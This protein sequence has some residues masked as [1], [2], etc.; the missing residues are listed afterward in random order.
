MNR[1]HHYQWQGS[2]RLK[3]SISQ[4]SCSMNLE[5]ALPPG[6]NASLLFR[7]EGADEV[8]NNVT[9]TCLLTEGGLLSL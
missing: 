5:K 1:N 2:A 3:A 7:T 9:G 8:L 4:P 6:C